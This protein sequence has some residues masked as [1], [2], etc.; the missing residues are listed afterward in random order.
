MLHR[1]HVNQHH[2]RSNKKHGTNK[3]VITIKTSKD[4]KIYI[5]NSIENVKLEEIGNTALYFVSDLSKAV[6]GEIQYVDCGFNIL[7]MPKSDT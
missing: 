4:N 6:T 1:I 5:N 3:P 2:I 7:G